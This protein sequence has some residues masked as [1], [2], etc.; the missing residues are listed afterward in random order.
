MLNPSLAFSHNVVLP[1]LLHYVRSLLMVEERVGELPAIAFV[2]LDHIS[3]T[4]PN[5]QQKCFQVF[6][7]S[8]KA[9]FS[10]FSS[11]KELKVKA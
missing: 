5:L 6:L 7:I 9:S 8:E 1:G 11:S 2:L 10:T 3:S 4:H